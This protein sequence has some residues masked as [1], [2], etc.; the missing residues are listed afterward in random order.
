M[1]VIA[2]AVGLVIVA[3]AAEMQQ[4]E[5]IDEPFFFQE[6]DSAID[7]DEVNARIDFASAGKNL[8]DV[9]MLLGVIHHL[10]D[11][12]ALP[13]QANAAL[14]QSFGEM[15]GSFGSVDALAGR[16]AMRWRGGHF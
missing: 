1:N 12:A 16:G 7:G 4:I 9:E 6:F 2:G 13:G 3:V 5:F 11:D 15:A 10:E 14:A 8:I